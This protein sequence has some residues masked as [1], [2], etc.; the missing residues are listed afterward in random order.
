MCYIITVGKDFD[1]SVL[2]KECAEGDY[3]KLGNTIR[4]N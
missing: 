4:L 3:I 2:L 1:G